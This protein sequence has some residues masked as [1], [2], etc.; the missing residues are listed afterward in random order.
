[1]SLG[2]I[3]VFTELSNMGDRDD[4][5]RYPLNIARNEV[6]ADDLR[7]YSQELERRSP[8]LFVQASPQCSVGMWNQ[9]H[10]RDG[11]GKSSIGATY[12]Q[13]F[14]SMLISL[15]SEWAESEMAAG[16]KPF[17]PT[18]STEQLEGTKFAA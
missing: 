11:Q 13:T 1:V 16:F 4:F 2:K 6:D 18:G 7:L 3:S 14:D 15:C 9:E 10:A 8:S 12:Q 5:R 17:Y